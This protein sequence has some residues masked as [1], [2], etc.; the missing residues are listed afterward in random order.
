MNGLDAGS[1]FAYSIPPSGAGIAQLVECQ[2][3]M[4]KVA[5]SNPVARSRIPFGLIAML[6]CAGASA[7]TAT[8]QLRAG[9][10]PRTGSAAAASL[11]SL[12][13]MDQGGFDALSGMS[14]TYSTPTSAEIATEG[15]TAEERLRDRLRAGDRTALMPLVLV[16]V[17][18]GE[19][20][21]A[22][23][24]LEGRGA[25]IPANRR[26]L[27][28]AASWYG[29]YS[30]HP[31]L[32]MLP[33]PPPDLEGDDA[34]QSIAA[35]LAAGWMVLPPDGLFHPEAFPSPVDMACISEAF[36]SGSFPHDGI[37]WLDEIDPFFRR[38]DE[39]AGR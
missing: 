9:M 8:W 36:P 11:V 27:A 19:P 5:G 26:D 32:A 34:A 38:T 7:D 6:L 33:E 15:I 13:V 22:S 21:R 14:S 18:G 23:A 4:L 12:V 10:I 29:R 30:L 20:G 24:C 16:L 37:I 3:P 28:M 35:V 39:A 1:S 2:P 31:Y 17:A 25:R